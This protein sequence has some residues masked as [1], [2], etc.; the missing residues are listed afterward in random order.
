MPGR[1]AG[2][3]RGRSREVLGTDKG[4]YGQRA[5]GAPQEDGGIEIKCFEGHLE[6][7]M[8]YK[9]LADAIE[10]WLEETGR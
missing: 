1:R 7:F 10:R 6:G 4:P 9:E 8:R 3:Q 2:R 5:A